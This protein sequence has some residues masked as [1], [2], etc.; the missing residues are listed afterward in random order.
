MMQIEWST[1]CADQCV[2]GSTFENQFA[3]LNSILGRSNNHD[4]IE[5]GLQQGILE[6]II[7]QVLQ[8]VGEIGVRCAS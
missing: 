1:S 8:T 5:G 4:A 3:C 7:V 2:T 6:E